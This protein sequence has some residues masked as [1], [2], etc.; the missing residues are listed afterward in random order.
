MSRH[1][2]KAIKKPVE[3]EYMEI[4]VS[5]AQQNRVIEWVGDRWVPGMYQDDGPYIHPRIITATGMET[6]HVGDVI[7]KDE[8]GVFRSYSKPEFNAQYE[9]VEEKE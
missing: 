8:Y 3:L 1:I 5:A 9:I 7:V 4:R 2:K 6:I